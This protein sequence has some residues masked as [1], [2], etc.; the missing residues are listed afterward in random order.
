MRSAACGA[1]CSPRRAAASGTSLRLPFQASFLEVQRAVRALG[2]AWI[3]RHHDDGLAVLL[4]QRLQQVEDLVTRL[5]DEITGRRVALQ[6][7]RIRDDR[8]RDADALLL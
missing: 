3:V 4:V 5:T 2:G 6:L 8:A 7:R 1:S